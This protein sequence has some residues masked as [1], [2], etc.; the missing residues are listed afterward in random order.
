MALDGP[1]LK[2]TMET[3]IR[4]KL[5]EKIKPRLPWDDM[6][7]ADKTSVQNGWDDIAGAVAEAAQEIVDE[8][9]GNAAVSSDGV[10]AAHAP[11][12]PATITALS[13]TVS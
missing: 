9:T 12:A 13:G 7:A 2:G 4:A 8:I 11:G 1:R 6:S 10:T 3:K 5:E